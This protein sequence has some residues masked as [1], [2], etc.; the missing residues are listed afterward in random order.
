MSSILE[1]AAAVAV[2]IGSGF[3]LLASIGLVRFPDL[4]TRIHAASKAGVVGAG[5]VLI[6]LAIVSVDLSIVLRSIAAIFF[7][8]LTTPISAHLLARSTYITRGH[9]ADI[10]RT[11]DLSD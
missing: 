5:F 6:G 9:S 11:D 10:T 8:L 3:G 7:L 2:L 1:I 4:Y